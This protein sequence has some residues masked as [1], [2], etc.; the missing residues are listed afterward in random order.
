MRGVTA[1]VTARRTGS[2][3]LVA[4]QASRKVPVLELTCSSSR[5]FATPQFSAKVT[6]LDCMVS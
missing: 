2:V 1:S 6:N 5:Y 3:N 4:I